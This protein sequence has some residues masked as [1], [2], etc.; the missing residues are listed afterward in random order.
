[1]DTKLNKKN[2]N[3]EFCI[4]HSVHIYWGVNY[5]NTTGQNGSPVCLL[6]PPALLVN[7]SLFL[8]VL[9]CLLFIPQPKLCIVPQPKLCIRVQTDSGFTLVQ[10]RG[11]IVLTPWFWHATVS[12]TNVRN[13]SIELSGTHSVFQ[14]DFWVWAAFLP[15][16]C[17][18]AFIRCPSHFL[19]SLTELWVVDL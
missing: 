19:L 14:Q 15:F 3:S 2:S 5:L 9:I 12:Q 8:S 1:M 4:L 16:Q 6:Q 7:T 17:F 11:T 13:A 10:G 18:H